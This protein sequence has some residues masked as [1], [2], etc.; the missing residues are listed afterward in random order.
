MWLGNGGNWFFGDPPLGWN[1]Y[2][3]LIKGGLAIEV[4]KFGEFTM[5]SNAVLGRKLNPSP[6]VVGLVEWQGASLLVAA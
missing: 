4:P 2:A 1:R 3:Q 6:P 5:R